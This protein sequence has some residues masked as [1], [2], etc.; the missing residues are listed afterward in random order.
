LSLFVCCEY[1]C[2]LRGIVAVLLSSVFSE[3]ALRFIPVFVT[4]LVP[5]QP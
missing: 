4:P 1:G 3:T 2:D 5:F